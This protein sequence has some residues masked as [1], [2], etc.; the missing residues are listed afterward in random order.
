MTRCLGTQGQTTG[1]MSLSTFLSWRRCSAGISCQ[2]RTFIIAMASKTT[3]GPRTWS[4]GRVR[5]LRGYASPTPLRGHARYL[6]GMRKPLPHPDRRVD[7]HQTDKRT[8]RRLE[9]SARSATGTTNVIQ[10]F[11][12]LNDLG[13]V[14]IRTRVLRDLSKSSPS[15]ACCA[16]LSPGDHAGK[17]PTGSVTVWFP[18]LPR[19]RA[20]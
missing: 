17:T 12:K 15:A 2:E 13:D 19:D 8:R 18:S 10:A 1:T 14:G 16:F 6:R 3:T 20:D 11:E 5:S 7:T 9:P 4:C